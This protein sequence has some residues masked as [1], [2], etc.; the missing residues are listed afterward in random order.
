MNQDV[1]RIV[2]GVLTSLMAVIPPCAATG[3]SA[4][5]RVSKIGAVS[6]KPVLIIDVMG[7]K[8][9]AHALEMTFFDP[10]GPVPEVQPQPVP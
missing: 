2:M 5:D 4:L 7:I 1:M 3:C 6:E 9:T 8:L 10:E